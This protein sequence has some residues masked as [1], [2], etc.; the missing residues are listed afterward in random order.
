[1]ILDIA[2]KNTYDDNFESS[3]VQSSIYF[4][5]DAKLRYFGTENYDSQVTFVLIL[6]LK[7]TITMEERRILFTAIGNI[8]GYHSKVKG[9]I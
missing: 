4:Y 3:I 1:M 5:K 7:G 6:K 8:K 9:T 2:G